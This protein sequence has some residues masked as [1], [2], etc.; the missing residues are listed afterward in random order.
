M[1]F[2]LFV[3][4]IKRSSRLNSFSLNGVK[5]WLKR[6]FL[7]SHFIFWFSCDVENIPNSVLK[8][9]KSKFEAT[10]QWILSTFKGRPAVLLVMLIREISEYLLK[11]CTV[12]LYQ[13]LYCIRIF[14]QQ[15]KNTHTN[16]FSSSPSSK[17]QPSLVVAANGG[18]AASI[19]HAAR[20]PVTFSRRC[21]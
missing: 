13:T 16:N 7:L 19:P 21:F 18:R 2:Y 17:F 5:N 20:G 6:H 4:T 10:E 8:Y 14:Y 3:G 9:I 15:Q 12:S 1:R 11:C